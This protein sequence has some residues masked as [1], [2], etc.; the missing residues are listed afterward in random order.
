MELTVLLTEA[1]RAS[2]E[3][4]GQTLEVVAEAAVKVMTI[5]HGWV[6]EVELETADLELL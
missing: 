3:M 6:M 1:I 4:V 5:L 2:V